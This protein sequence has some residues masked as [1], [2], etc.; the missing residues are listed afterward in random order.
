MDRKEACV[1]LSLKGFLHDVPAKRWIVNLIDEAANGL[2]NIRTSAAELRLLHVT[3]CLEQGIDLGNDFLNNNLFNR[4][5]YAVSLAVQGAQNG[6]QTQDPGLAQSGHL[7]WQQRPAGQ[8]PP[9][10]SGWLTPVHLPYLFW[11]G[12]VL[13]SCYY[14]IDYECSLFE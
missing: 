10:R 12:L 2:A 13:D 1:P 11:P 7:F 8:L 9:E 6:W 5:Y 4:S 3:R 14:C